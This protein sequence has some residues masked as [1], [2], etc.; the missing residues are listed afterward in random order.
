[1]WYTQ[2]ISFSDANSKDTEPHRHARVYC[3][4]VCVWWRQRVCVWVCV[5]ATVLLNNT[6]F[7]RQNFKAQHTL[8]KGGE[9]KRER[10][11]EVGVGGLEGE[12]KTKIQDEQWW[13]GQRRS[14]GWLSDGSRCLAVMLNTLC[15][16]LTVCLPACSQPSV[17]AFWQRYTTNILRQSSFVCVIFLYFFLGR[18][19]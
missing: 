18:H 9:Q 4:C 16:R 2:L 8:R 6:S 12:T 17:S 5:C 15:V 7:T 3:M 14:D 13:E 1:M 11:R 19:H 10:A